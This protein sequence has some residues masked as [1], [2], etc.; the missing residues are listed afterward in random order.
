MVINLFLFSGAALALL[1]GSG[2]AK[3][4]ITGGIHG[5][6]ETKDESD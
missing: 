3:G 6:G 1:D 2:G 5:R 4:A